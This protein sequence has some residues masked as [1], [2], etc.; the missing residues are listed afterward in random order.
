MNKFLTISQLSKLL[1]LI[2]PK[3]R[4]PLNHILRYWEKE[5]KEIKPKKIN[6]RRYYSNK[7]IEEIKKIKFLLKNKGMTIS[8]VKNLLRS[9]II[10]LDDD[11]SNSLKDEYYK[12]YL[13]TKSKNILKKIN[14][15]KSHG[16]KNS[17]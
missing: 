15:I 1:G 11:D 12:L 7:Q 14:L 5:F 9:N 4:K 16:K 17:S 3:T 13:K 8:G 2:D 10:K 6:N